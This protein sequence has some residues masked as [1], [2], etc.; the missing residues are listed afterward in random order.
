M[1][2]KFF[3]STKVITHQQLADLWQSTK[4]EAKQLVSHMSFEEKLGQ[5]LMLGFRHWGD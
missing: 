4:E 5:M 3:C 2:V 1:Y